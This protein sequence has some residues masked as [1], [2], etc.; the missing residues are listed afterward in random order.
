MV[1]NNSAVNTLSS[2]CPAGD[3]VEPRRQNDADTH[4]IIAADEDSQQPDSHLPDRHTIPYSRFKEVIDERNRLR[5]ELAANQNKASRITAQLSD[6]EL[7]Y[8]WDENPSQ[9]AKLMFSDLMRDMRTRESA[10]DEYLSQ[11]LERYPEL[12]D[13]NHAILHLA[14]DI[15]SVE[16]PDLKS[17]PRGLAIATEIA[18]ARYYREQVT[19]NGPEHDEALR[20]LEATRSAN[21]RSVPGTAGLQTGPLRKHDSLSA[22]EQRIARMMGVPVDQYVKNKRNKKGGTV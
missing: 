22:D 6:E 14:K 10:R 11:T 3:D 21:L 15:L 5:E 12:Q 16:M 1:N 20:A 9:A 17:D 7:N 18:A 13:T 19:D 8:L 2:S 4:Q